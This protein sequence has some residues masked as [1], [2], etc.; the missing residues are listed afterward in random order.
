MKIRS[1]WMMGSALAVTCGLAAAQPPP[2]EPLFRQNFEDGRPDPWMVFGEKARLSL[3]QKT[4]NVKEGTT[5]LQFDYPIEKG[6]LSALIV[7]T[8]GGVPARVKSFRFWVKT[9]YATPLALV[10]EEQGGGRYLYVF[11]A[12]KDTWQRV[13]VSPSEFVQAQDKDAPQDPNG[14]LDLDRV[15]AVALGDMSQLFI[16]SDEFARILGV[17][18]GAH[19]L[20]LDDF[21]VSEELPPLP[22][23][24]A[25]V[26]GN[27][28]LDSFLHPQLAWVATGA[29][30]LKST[31]DQGVDGQGL[32]ADYEQAQDKLAGLMKLL[33]K[34]R[35]AG[36]GQLTFSVA[37]TNPT[38]LLVQLEEKSGGK[39]N[40]IVDVP[41]NALATEAKLAPASFKV[42]DD[43]KDDNDQLDLDQVK[44][45]LFLDATGLLGLGEGSNTLWISRLRVVPA[46]AV[47]AP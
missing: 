45:I 31:R 7:P 44:Q 4:E 17:K 20:Y 10:L 21:V 32:Q 33:P 15:A 24:A 29:V 27:E 14:K 35:L 19:T 28:D 16:Q 13:E 6:Q 40:A 47:P 39:Y 42:S 3:T 34:G 36:M 18:A 12:P 37:A 11:S 25:P 8:P 38:T 1:G 41:G 43:S 22:E 9:D 30:R 2:P 5:A 46:Q 26:T 23:D